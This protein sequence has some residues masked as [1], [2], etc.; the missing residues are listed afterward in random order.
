M[1]TSVEDSEDLVCCCLEAMKTHPL[2]I[3]IAKEALR[4]LSSLAINPLQ[5]TRNCRTLIHFN[6]HIICGNRLK[7]MGDQVDLVVAAISCLVPLAIQGR[8]H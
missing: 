5:S 7:D 3:E 4:V 6:V 1:E 8:M 2:S